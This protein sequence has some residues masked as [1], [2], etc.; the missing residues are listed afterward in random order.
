M[1][2]EYDVDLYKKIARFQVNDIVE[3]SNRKGIRSV[4]HVKN[5]TKL[6][7][8]ELQLLVSG[9]SDRFTK[10][11]ILYQ[12]YSNLASFSNVI[13]GSQLTKKES[14]EVK[15][16]IDIYQLNGFVEH[17][18]VNRYITINGIW[19]LFPTIRSMNDHGNGKIVEGIQPRYFEIVCKILNISGDDGTPLKGFSPY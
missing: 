5:I 9:G 3:V 7:W 13:R 1:K 8:Q 10:M 14:D 12:H 16:Y 19:S 17:H 4:I 6:S 18:E 2:I 15:A 11:V